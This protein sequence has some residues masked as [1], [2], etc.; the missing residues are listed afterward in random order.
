MLRQEQIELINGKTSIIESCVKFAC[1]YLVLPKVEIQFDDCPSTRF[2]TMNNAAESFLDGDEIGHIIINGPWFVERIELH[3]DDVEYF[4]F[5]E[6]RHLHQQNQI[7]LLHMRE[8]VR[9]PK[10]V[11]EKWQKEFV[12]YIRNEGKTSKNENIRQEV[13]IDATAYGIIL[14]ILYQNGK[15]PILSVPKELMDL[16]DERLQKYIDTLPEFRMY[17]PVQNKKSKTLN[18]KNKIGRND[19][20]PCGS[21]QKYKRCCGK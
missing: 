10:E 19:L 16:A 2:P 20:C 18:R 13:E 4:V 1:N 15:K 14:E 8:T 21:R 9:E 5:H 12:N 17:S 11:I 6:L 7:R 3:Q